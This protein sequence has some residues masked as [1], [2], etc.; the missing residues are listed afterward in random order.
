MNRG[1]IWLQAA[2]QN[3]AAISIQQA[4]FTGN[5]HPLQQLLERFMLQGICAN[6]GFY[7]GMML[8]LCAVLGSRSRICSNRESDLGSFDIQLTPLA[9]GIPGFPLE[10]KH[11]RDPHTDL[12][13]LAEKALEQIEEKKYD[14]ALRSA[15]VD[16][17]IRIGIAFR[18]KVRL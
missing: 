10:F 15:G 3:G 7:H 2:K 12:D 5:A 14:I 11:T 4:I 13:S 8:G 17:I 6:E 9:N 16:P 18:G 1:F